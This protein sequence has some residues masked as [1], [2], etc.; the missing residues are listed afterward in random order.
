MK[1]E[2]IDIL[3]DPRWEKYPEFQ[4]HSSGG[5]FVVRRESEILFEARDLMVYPEDAFL[6][7]L[8][9]GIRLAEE[10]TGYPKRVD[11]DDTPILETPGGEEKLDPYRKKE[12][13]A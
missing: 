5:R 13:N 12:D 7:G 10:R 3:V 4:G 8:E 1:I 2:P 11:N 9:L 6:A